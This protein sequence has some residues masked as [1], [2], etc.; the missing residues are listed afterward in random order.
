MMA[1]IGWNPFAV[2]GRR[3]RTAWPDLSERWPSRSRLVATV[4]AFRRQKRRFAAASGCRSKV[5]GMILPAGM[6]DPRGRPGQVHLAALE[7]K[8]P[9]FSFPHGVSTA[10][11]ERP[12][13]DTQGVHR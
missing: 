8:Y 3:C 5:R 13:T 4:A 1:S 2:P 9:R 10:G 6:D 7:G 12:G 11:A